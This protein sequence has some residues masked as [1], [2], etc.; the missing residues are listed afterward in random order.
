MQQGYC[1]TTLKEILHEETFIEIVGIQ[2]VDIL[3]E[4]GKL[5]G[6]KK[7]IPKYE[8]KTE[9]RTETKP[10]L[11]SDTRDWKEIGEQAGKKLLHI[12][13]SE[14]LPKE[15]CLGASPKEIAE[16]A[17]K[18]DFEC[19]AVSQILLFSFWDSGEKDDH[20]NSVIIRGNMGE[21]LKAGKPKLL[22][23]WWPPSMYAGVPVEMPTQEQIKQLTS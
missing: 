15:K 14:N 5:T 1:L 17:L 22:D 9:S 23:K 4:E 2:E 3:D 11:D 16:K 8:E 7:Q 20:G 18:G 6:E 19:K 10:D 13:G 21:W 12:I